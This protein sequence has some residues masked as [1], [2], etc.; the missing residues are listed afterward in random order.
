MAIKY[1]K[2]FHCK[3]LQNLPHFGLK[4]CHLAT[5]AL[6]INHFRLFLG[7]GVGLTGSFYGG[8]SLIKNT[9]LYEVFD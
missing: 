4:I 5:L 7:G 6:T 1:I 3:S 9:L 8:G 2:I